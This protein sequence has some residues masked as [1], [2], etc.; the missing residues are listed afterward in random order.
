MDCHRQ[1]HLANFFRLITRSLA[2]RGMRSLLPI[3]L[4]FS[5]SQVLAAERAADYVPADTIAF[6]GTPTPLAA[7]TVVKAIFG[8]SGEFIRQI[9]DIIDVPLDGND[10]DEI[11]SK[12]AALARGYADFLDDPGAFAEPLGLNIQAL[13][14]ALY[15]SGI[16]PVLRIAVEDTEKLVARIE[17][18]ES[19]YQL[20]P[21]VTRQSGTELRFYGDTTAGASRGIALTIDGNF[22]TLAISLTD[23]IALFQS[24]GL[25]DRGPSLN[26]SG[27]LESLQKEH[28]YS[29]Q[30][31][32]F[33]DTQE[34][35]KAVTRAD[36]NTGLQLAEYVDSPDVLD[37]FRTP[38]CQAEL[39]QLAS[40]WPRIVSG[41][42]ALDSAQ[43]QTN[44]ASKTLVEIDHTDITNSLRATRG[45]IS[46][47]LNTADAVATVGIG[48][49]FDQIGLHVGRLAT[50]FSNLDYEC[51][52][53]QP[54]SEVPDEAIRQGV[55]G[56]TMSTGMLRGVRGFNAALFDIDVVVPEQ[57]DGDL[58]TLRLG[59][60]DAAMTL[61]ALDPHILLAMARMIPAVA[62]FRF[63]SNNEATDISQ[64][65]AETLDTPVD[66]DINL[67]IQDHGIVSYTGDTGSVFANTR[68]TTK[69]IEKNG[70]FY[71]S[72][73]LDLYKA[74]FIDLVKR[75]MQSAN[76]QNDNL[77]LTVE[78]QL[79]LVSNFY[80]GGS[81]RYLVDFSEHGIEIETG[82]SINLP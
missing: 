59:S 28:G 37:V 12:L 13:D 52:A 80:G 36:N 53:L 20:T 48:I 45:H 47:A 58:D 38:T 78:E 49:D 79:A 34:L 71:L 22:A 39:K 31:L 66:F 82:L 50:L 9:L 73:D 44:I 65:I 5:A 26:E 10:S 40:Y 68:R 67:E 74:R 81:Y 69:E 27:K 61:D 77:D 17:R 32:G 11:E 25:F 56:L 62:N 70:L 8:N 75:S 15:F 60:L 18:L 7:D 43:S 16:N 63:P 76:K 42:T 33:V 55:L 14:F 29:G 2:S 57:F 51:P 4:V 19:D 35:V 6:M 46:P 72:I 41:I 54:I 64:Q 23:E 30:L 21:T 24:L 3:C 1:R